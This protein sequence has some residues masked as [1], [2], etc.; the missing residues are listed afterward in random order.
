MIT[1]RYIIIN[2]EVHKSLNYRSIVSQM[3]RPLL[4][5][6]YKGSEVNHRFPDLFIYLF[7]YLYLT[8]N[9][10]NLQFVKKRETSSLQNKNCEAN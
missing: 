7:I 5:I 6:L 4:N 1:F 2:R 8:N 10:T 3:E 9:F